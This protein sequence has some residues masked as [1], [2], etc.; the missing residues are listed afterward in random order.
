MNIQRIQQ[1]LLPPLPHRPSCPPSRGSIGG[2]PLE[3]SIWRHSSSSYFRKAVVWRWVEGGR[4]LEQ[5]Q[6]LSAVSWSCRL[7]RP[8][9]SDLRTTRLKKKQTNKKPL[10]RLQRRGR[11][12]ERQRQR[13]RDRWKQLWQN[14]KGKWERDGGLYPG[15]LMLWVNAPTTWRPG[16]SMETLRTTTGRLHRSNPC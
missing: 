8:L 14:G 11:E 9:I 12:G 4:G 7:Y 6:L 1:S 15:L 10:T 5:P 13:V 3:L 2:L 16:C